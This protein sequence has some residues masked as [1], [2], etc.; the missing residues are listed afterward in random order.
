MSTDQALAL[1]VWDSTGSVTGPGLSSR[2]N[3]QH[4][5]SVALCSGVSPVLNCCILQQMR[6]HGRFS[7]QFSSCK[8]QGEL[9]TVQGYST[10][11]P[12]ALLKLPATELVTDSVPTVI[13][14]ATVTSG[15]FHFQG[16]QAPSPAPRQWGEIKA[17]RQG[18]LKAAEHAE[19]IPAL[20][21]SACT[22]PQPC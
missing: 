14:K 16:C 1:K 5:I 6:H 13:M 10:V 20:D 15:I 11:K 22:C 8:H 21:D 7:L 9:A 18:C 17:P 12:R 2:E 4:H 3:K 19:S